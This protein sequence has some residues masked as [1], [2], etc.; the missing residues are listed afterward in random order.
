MF[1]KLYKA[2]LEGRGFRPSFSVTNPEENLLR[3]S[4]SRFHIYEVH[5]PIVSFPVGTL[6][7]P[8]SVNLSLQPWFRD[9]F[10][11]KL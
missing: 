5:P 1:A 11:L 8:I 4:Y 7:K 10:R 6:Q 2:V 9:G 3:W